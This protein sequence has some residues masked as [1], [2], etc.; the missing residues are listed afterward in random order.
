LTG[1]LSLVYGAALWISLQPN[2][3]SSILSHSAFKPL[4]RYSYGLYIVHYMLYP[5]FERIFGPSVL[6]QWTGAGDSAIYLYFI[7]ASSISFAIAMCSYHLFE[8][9]FLRLKTRF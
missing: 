2:K 8:V 3:L 4:A 7:L 6:R 5:L 9:H 1:T